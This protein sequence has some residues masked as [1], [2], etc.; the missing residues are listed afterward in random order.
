MAAGSPTLMPFRNCVFWPL[1]VP[2]AT[3]PA[4]RPPWL[5]PVSGR[6][7][8]R[9]GIL[10]SAIDQMSRPPG[11]DC[12]SCWLSV[13]LTFALVVSTVGDWPATV[14][15]SCTFATSSC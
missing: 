11:V 12:S 1:L 6:F 4:C 8:T 13:V 7:V 14:I 2:A 9:P 10:Y 5:P 15:D 3:M